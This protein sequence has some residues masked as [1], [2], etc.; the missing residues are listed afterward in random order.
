MKFKE[1]KKVTLFKE[2]LA[3][4]YNYING[5]FSLYGI[6]TNKSLMTLKNNNNNSRVV[7]KG[8]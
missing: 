2:L 7:K 3:I 6:Y 8:K 4:K 5:N 1:I